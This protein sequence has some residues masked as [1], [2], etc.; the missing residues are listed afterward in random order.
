MKPII[1]LLHPY[2]K[3]KVVI[4][5]ESIIHSMVEFNDGSILA[6]LGTPNMKIP[7]QYALTYPERMDTMVEKLDF[8]KLGAINFSKPDEKRFPAFKVSFM[9]RRQ[10]RWYHACRYECCQRSGSV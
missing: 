9:K 7:I 10:I 5:P 2:E 3:I 1:Y 6:H 8:Y 4:Q